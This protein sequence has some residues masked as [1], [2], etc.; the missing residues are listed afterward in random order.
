MAEQ[1]IIMDRNHWRFPRMRGQSRALS[2]SRWSL[3]FEARGRMFKT[4]L[5]DR[6]RRGREHSQ[7]ISR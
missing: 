5:E 4:E 3:L 6:T 1:L 2:L 7:T